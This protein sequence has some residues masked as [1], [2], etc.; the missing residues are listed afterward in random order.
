MRFY[1]GVRQGNYIMDPEFQRDFIWPEDKQSKLIESVLMRVPLPV[2]YVA[3][4]DQGTYGSRRWI[5]TPLDIQ[6]FRRW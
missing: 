5:A 3:E 1:E 6:A 4:D 2:F